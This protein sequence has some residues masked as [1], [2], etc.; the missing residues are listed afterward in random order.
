MYAMYKGLKGGVVDN[1]RNFPHFQLDIPL[2]NKFSKLEISLRNFFCSSNFFM[3]TYMRSQMSL[4]MNA[5]HIIQH[6]KRLIK[7]GQCS[8]NNR[9]DIKSLNPL[10]SDH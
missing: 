2:K 10:D 3:I 9:I 1:G 8:R 4:V 7:F 5:Q 6:C